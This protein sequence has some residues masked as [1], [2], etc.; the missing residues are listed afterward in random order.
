MTVYVSATDTAKLIKRALK[1]Q[2]P[3]TK[4]SVR[5]IK[6]AG[7]ATV[8]VEWVHGPT[9]PAVDAIVKDFEG[10]APDA[11]GDF[12]D[13]ITHTQGGQQIRYGTRHIHTRRMITRATYESI[14]NE[15]LAALNIGLLHTQRTFP[16]PS[17]V[18]KEVPHF[19]AAQGNV[20]EF[21][22]ALA[23]NREDLPI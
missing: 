19:A 6:Y 12:S 18:L 13:P 22:R 15:V 14:Q 20:H 3:E 11:T 10:T 7:G 23:E 5:T 9:T 17:L 21:I 8:D 1:V 16:V 2:F 4:F